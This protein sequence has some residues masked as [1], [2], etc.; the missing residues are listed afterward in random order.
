M[1][2]AKPPANTASLIVFGL[3]PDKNP[4]AGTFPA[5]MKDIIA[6]AA[7]SLNLV[8]IAVEGPDLVQVNGQ[9]PVGKILAAGRAT[10]PIV[11]PALYERL[12][13]AIPRAKKPKG[14]CL[15][16]P[17]ASWRDIAVGHHVLA[18]DNLGSDSWY[19]AVVLE[20][21]DAETFKLRFRDYPEEGLVV[22]RRDQLGLMPRT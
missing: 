16:K 15:P 17:P 4:V 8:C 11:K 20:Q 7:A 14:V 13:A 1:T 18:M 5:E 10:V 9:L 22:R 21:P 6:K 19:E 2:T 12:L 3:D